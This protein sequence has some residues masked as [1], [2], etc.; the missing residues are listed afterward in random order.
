MKSKTLSPMELVSELLG[1]AGKQRN[2]NNYEPHI[3][4]QEFHKSDKFCTLYLGGNRA[5]KT[6]AGVNEDTWRAMGRHPFKAVKPAPVS[7]RY[8]AT[9][10]PSGVEKVALPTF[11][12]WLPVSM[13]IN[14][15][16]SDSWSASKRRLTLTNGSFIEFM[17]ND[18]ELDSFAGAS[19]DVVHF[20]EEP[21]KAV[22]N[23]NKM[24]LIDREG[25]CYITMTPV[26]G[27]TWVYDDLYEMRDLDPN[28]LVIEVDMDD[29]PYL[30]AA[31]K[32]A[33]LQGLSTD[34][35]IAR[36]QGRFVAQTG[37][38]FRDFNPEHHVIP[39]VSLPIPPGVKIYESMDHG[40]NNPTAWHWHAVFQD[41]SIVT[42][43][44]H[45]RNEWTV[46][47]HVAA[48]KQKRR[49]LKLMGRIDL[50]V[51]D[52][53]I[54][55]RN[56]VTG[57]SIQTQYR[58]QGIS[59]A[60]ANNDVLG[61]INKMNA[62]IRQRKWVITEDCPN[63]IREMRKYRWKTWESKRI[64]SR[65][66]V[67][68]EPHKKDD[69]AVDDCRYLFSFMPHLEPDSPSVSPDRSW[70]NME[71]IGAR[72]PALLGKN[73][74]RFA[75]PPVPKQSTEWTHIDEHLGGLF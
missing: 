29:N 2:L 47:Q 30:T 45:Y 19:R 20:D 49:D 23:E 43:G 10:F 42:F 12:Q 11:S 14:G 74:Y 7:I 71:M 8:V 58:L 3:K 35:K 1:K 62:Y 65:N 4:Q 64:A 61:G 38:I 15:A 75:L 36:K 48:V 26:E 28:L 69:H 50:S 6:V 57:N 17:S 46:D 63:L 18:Q 41:G 53:A 37:L 44:E 56:G 16:W 68:D 13:L 9:D 55:Q 67:R 24:R 70:Q 39:P 54:A 52:P 33:A 5:G 27:M 32:A 31:G 34:E 40:F 73:G 72:L 21:D 66:N 51:G 60:L 25:I 22:F 59:I